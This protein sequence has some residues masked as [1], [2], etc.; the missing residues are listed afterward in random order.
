MGEEITPSKGRVLVTGGSGFIAS[1]VIDVFLDEGFEIVTTVRSDEKGQGIVESAKPSLRE[2]VSYAIVRDISEDGAFDSVFQNEPGFDIVV[3]TASPYHHNVQDP[4]KDFLEPAIKGTTGLLKSVK[5]NA[6]TVKRVVITSSSAAVINPLKHAKV[7]DE[8]H[9]A[10]WT[11]EDALVPGTAYTAS[12]KLSEQA[13]WEFMETER[14]NFDLATINCTF[15]YGPVQRNLPNLDAMNTSNHLIRDLVQGKLKDGLPPTVPV[16]TF[17]DVRDVAQSHLKAAIVP[18]AGGNR[19]YIV[20]GYF[21]NK[22]IADEI[23]RSFPE[24]AERLPDGP[25]DLP[26][27]VFGIDISKSRRVLGLEYVSLAKSVKDTV[28]SILDMA[29]ELR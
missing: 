25:D 21:S 11:R 9:W 14:P 8:T 28:Q 2:R 6:P 23:R 3:H 19:F 26:K 24:L 18:E 27:D 15:T 5:T 29:P 22:R 1:H 17:V 20:G 16:C 13:A 10:P 12:K 7:Y 4:V